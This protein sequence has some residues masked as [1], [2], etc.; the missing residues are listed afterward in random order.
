MSARAFQAHEVEPVNFMYE[1]KLREQEAKLTRRADLS[2]S[3]EM[4]GG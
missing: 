2:A 1:S 3:E 4:R